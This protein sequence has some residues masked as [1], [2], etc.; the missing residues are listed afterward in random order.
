MQNAPLTSID[1]IRIEV[2]TLRLVMRAML[3][4]RRTLPWS[5]FRLRGAG[6]I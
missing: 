4:Y 5:A 6:V 1:D 2:V 3:A